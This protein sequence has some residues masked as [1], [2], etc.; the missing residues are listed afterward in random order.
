MKSVFGFLIFLILL[1]CAPAESKS[2]EFTVD[3]NSLLHFGGSAAIAAAADLSLHATSLS[4]KERVVASTL[5][6][7]GVGTYKEF[8]RDAY[9]D[10]GDMTF[11][12]IGSAAGSLAGEG[13]GIVLLPYR[14]QGAT[15]LVA[16]INW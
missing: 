16:A 14:S 3:S 12:L 11:N 9:V 4:R 8:Y 6:A 1:I 15:G 7:L 2:A 5:L 13:L 10:L